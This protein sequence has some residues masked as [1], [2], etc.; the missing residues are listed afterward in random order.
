MDA[1]IFRYIKS[2]FTAGIRDWI[3]AH[4]QE[5]NE[6]DPATGNPPLIA[7]VEHNQREIVQLLLEHGADVNITDWTGKSTALDQ[8]DD[9]GFRNLVT[10]LKDHGGQHKSGSGFHLAAKNGDLDTVEK[11]L[12]SGQGIN[13]VDATRGWSALHY[14]SH[15][16][17]KHLVEFLLMRGADPNQRDFLGSATAIDVLDRTSRGAIVALLKRAG[18]KP[19]AGTSIHFCAETGDFEGV[20]AFCDADTRINN[21]DEKNGWMPI[22]FAVNANDVDMVEFLIHLGANVNGADFKGEI[23]PLDL[24]FKNGNVEMQALLQSKGAVRKR[25]HD[26]EAKTGNTEFFVSPS[27]KKQIQEFLERREREEAALRKIQ[28]E[29]GSKAPATSANTKATGAATTARKETQKISWMDFLRSKNKPVP[30]PKPP[31]QGSTPAPAPKPKTPRKAVQRVERIDTEVKSSRLELDVKQEAYLLFMDIIG[32]SKKS[33]DEQKQVCKDL[34]LLV[35]GTLQFKTANALEKLIILPT[36]DGMVMGFFT[37][38]EDAVLC[39]VDL[40]R[41]VRVRTDFALRLG[42]HCGEVYPVE[43]INGNLNI[44]GDG[45]NMAQRVMDAAE[46]NQLL[47]SAAVMTRLQ[48]PSFILVEDLGPVRVKHGTVLQMYNLHGSDF[49]RKGFPS[50]RAERVEL[51]VEPEA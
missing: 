29:A 14:A 28:Q 23:A 27:I 20:Q 5:I 6:R 48:R 40:A 8:A 7:A 33:T 44:T 12:S 32:F 24:A 17:Q 38:L 16:G 4:A 13:E 15:Y 43:D 3:R 39:A 11:F 50:S 51:S 31:T 47:V 9:K 42:V 10:L 45:I 41:K 18:C 30:S 49:G 2:G 21:R 34:G 46:D 1:S 25:K 19:V 22:H 26:G 37:Y 35:K 36:G